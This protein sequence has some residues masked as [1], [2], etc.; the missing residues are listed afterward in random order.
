L[1]AIF[2]TVV[3]DHVVAANPCHIK[4]AGRDKSEER[5]PPTAE[6]VRRLADAMPPHL[7]IAVVIAAAVPIRRNEFLGLHRRDVDCENHALRVERQLE[8]W[9]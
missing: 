4:G 9:L 6:E 3:V 8:N 1:K 2:S 7:R 5:V